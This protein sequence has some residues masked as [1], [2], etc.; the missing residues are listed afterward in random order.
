M[1]G[2]GDLKQGLSNILGVLHLS[3]GSLIW[4]RV[5][6]PE[7]LGICRRGPDPRANPV[8]LFYN[9]NLELPLVQSLAE[10]LV[11]WHLFC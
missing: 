8:R 9:R 6:C 11:A 3:E 2:R 1:S 10:G 5:T 4:G 7:F